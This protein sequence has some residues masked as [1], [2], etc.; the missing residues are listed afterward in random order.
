M[1]IKLNRNLSNGPWAVSLCTRET[2]QTV[3]PAYISRYF[4]FQVKTTAGRWIEAVPMANTV[5]VN[6]ADLMQRW[7][8]DRL[9]STV[10]A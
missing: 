9:L 1:A 10:L 3:T 8:A 6:I 4:D 2:V 7:T 5:L